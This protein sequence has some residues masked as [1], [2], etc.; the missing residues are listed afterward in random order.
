MKPQTPNPA[1]PQDISYSESVK[2]TGFF[3][4]VQIL[5]LLASLV[6]NKL[7]AVLLS[8]LGVGLSSLYQSITHFL[9][10]ACN[11]GVAFSSIREISELYAKKDEQGVEK[12]VEIVR[13]WSVWTAVAGTLVCIIL[14]PLISRL[15]FA[16]LSHVVSICILSPS[17]GFMTVAAAELSILKALRRLKRI[18]LISLL[19]ALVTIVFTVPFYYIFGI[20]G[21]LPAL[22]LSTFAVMVTHLSLSLSVVS[23]HVNLRSLE[24]Y[25]AGRSLVRVGIPYILSAIVNMGT[26]T[27]L[28]VFITRLGGLDHVGLYTMGYNL[29]FTYAGVVFA[30]LDADYFPRLA[31]HNQDVC[32]TNTVVNRQIRVCLLFMS[33]L[34][35]LFTT[36]MPLVIRILYSSAFLPMTTMACFASLHLFFKAMT[37]PVAYL[38]LAKG[39]AKIYF[40]MEFAYDVFLLIAVIAGYVIG[41]ITWT[42]VALAL[43]GVFDMLLIFNV[44]GRRYAFRFSTQQLPFVLQQLLCVVVALAAGLQ[45][46]ITFR[47]GAGSILFIISAI[48][49]Y[50]IIRKEMD[51]FNE[52]KR[53]LIRKLNK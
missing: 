44:Y 43:A 32:L 45:K 27:A 5:T 23:W 18:A 48:L 40:F 31:A 28:S 53:I 16:D 1:E 12:K 29:V 36:A 10:N 21:V 37:L 4:V 6:R 14:S 3:S 30:A 15:A 8:T 50:N 22:L 7:A 49:S 35:V 41:G 46:D 9:H 38:S 13:T 25:R 42:G 11:L 17:V 24:Y 19:S 47:V 51:L 33:P 20:R 39:D 2:Y 34:L 26:A 52:V